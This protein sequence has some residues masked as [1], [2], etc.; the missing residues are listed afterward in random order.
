LWKRVLR[1][2]GK[3]DEIDLSLAVIDSASLRAVFGGRTPAPTPQI[4]GKTAAN[5]I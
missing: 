2:L 3:E 4:A 5:G 1:H